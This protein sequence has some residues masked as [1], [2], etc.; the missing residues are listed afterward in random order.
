[1]ASELADLRQ[2]VPHDAATLTRLLERRPDVVG[3]PPPLDL[4][5]LADRLDD[6]YSVVSALQCAS[7]PLIQ[8]AQAVVGLGGC[9][10]VAQVSA[11]LGRNPE[12]VDPF[13]SW[14]HERLLLGRNGPE[15]L[16]SFGLL[17]AVGD[18]LRLGPA[19]AD[20]LEEQT[21]DGLRRMLLLL[22]EPRPVRKAD[23]M[24]ALGA[25]LRD[26]GWVRATVSSAP[27]RVRGWLLEIAADDGD[28][29]D[30]HRSYD[31]AAQRAARAALTWAGE[32]GLV[33]VSSWGSGYAMSREVTL[34]LRGTDQRAPFDPVAP[35]PARF[36]VD[37]V[38]LQRSVASAATSFAA[39]A[40]AVLDRV[41]RQPPNQ[42]KSGGV[43]ARELTKLAKATGVADSTVRLVLELAARLELFAFDAT[44]LQGSDRLGQWRDAEPAERYADL[45]DAWW[46]AGTIPT[47]DR[48][49]DKARPA[50][51]GQ[52]DCAGCR[53]G[54]H[55]LVAAVGAADGAVLLE[56]A[57]ALALWNRPLLHPDFVGDVA[58]GG[59][60]AEATVLGVLGSVA[61]E[62][63][64]RALSPIGAALLDGDRV[65]LLTAA[66]ALLPA[67]TV[68]VLLGADLTAVAPG[69]P[70]TLVT[71]LLD[72]CAERESGGGAVTW[73]F[74]P[75]SV[76]RALD[77]GT[78]GAELAEKIR[79]IARNGVPQ[80]LQYLIDDVGRRHGSM[81]VRTATSVVRSDDVALLAQAAA[82]RSLHR[83]GLVQLAPTVLTSTAPQ[84]TTLDAL[85]AAGYLPVPDEPA[86][87]PAPAPAPAGGDGVGEL[88]REHGSVHRVDDAAQ[89][90]DVQPVSAGALAH[91]LLDGHAPAPAAGDT[92]RWVRQGAPSMPPAHAR[93][94]ADAVDDGTAVHI[95][96]V[97]TAG[98]TTERTISGLELFGAEVTAFCHLRRDE[99]NFSLRGIRM[100]RPAS[101]A[102]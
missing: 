102:R 85:R 73:R 76:R 52:A 66:G 51:R 38:V 63:E 9:T 78:T 82:D 100:V 45:V 57:G 64:G 55:A 77:G 61:L 48:V 15:V 49:E 97:S 79:S 33:A 71:S 87:A 99:R 46:T 31:P 41:R 93:L 68:D 30:Q 75:G 42:L 25:L 90:G 14:L 5:E 44:T 6:P 101:A 39:D 58:F 13:L 47:E 34:A 12:I 81:R 70:S 84:Q 28:D 2:L 69:A 40:A 27:E 10:S 59:S 43:G 4:D 94:L 96:Y 37:P 89:A 67:A 92:E 1:M 17:S 24:A 53:N 21:A 60:W 35:T 91:A 8:C 88:V 72:G 83:L 50:L 29:T 7:L 62:G 18:P 22:G 98:R 65:A 54:R 3:P 19:L 36:A 95:T 16:A 74:S 26:P 23:A 32:R 20:L 86:A 11:L 80:P 56:A